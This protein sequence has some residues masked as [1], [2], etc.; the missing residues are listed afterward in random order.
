MIMWVRI[1]IL[2][3][4]CKC[5]WFLW[6]CAHQIEVSSQNRIVMWQG[7]GKLFRPLISHVKLYVFVCPGEGLVQVFWSANINSSF[8]NSEVGLLEEKTKQ[9]KS[10]CGCNGLPI[11]TSGRSERWVAPEF[12]GLMW[13]LYHFRNTEIQNAR[14]WYSGKETVGTFH[15]FVL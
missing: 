3:V 7:T 15:S 13:V 14:L 10:V 1:Q 6:G 5:G 2:W 4:F 11:S 9:N 8:W 12:L